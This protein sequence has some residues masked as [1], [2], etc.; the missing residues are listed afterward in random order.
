MISNLRAEYSVFEN[1]MEFLKEV[2]ELISGTM[3]CL[4]CEITNKGPGPSAAKFVSE[5]ILLSERV[6]NRMLHNVTNNFSVADQA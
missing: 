3:D 2:T 1:F 5:R 4:H 6:V